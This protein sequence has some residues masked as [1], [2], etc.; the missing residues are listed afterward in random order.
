ME[1]YNFDQDLSQ[2]AQSWYERNA[3]G[4]TPEQMEGLLDDV[5]S[6]WL[7]SVIPALGVTPRAYFEVLS[8]QRLADL[9]IAYEEIHAQP[10]VMME[11]I[12]ERKSMIPLL[13]D[14]LRNAV[15]GER[16]EMLIALLEEMGDTSVY[17]LYLDWICDE[18][19]DDEIALHAIEVMQ[20]NANMVAREL[21][22]RLKDASDKVK[23]RIAD[24]IVYAKPTQDGLQLLIDFFMTGK[25][26]QL[27]AA[28]LG[29]Y[30]DARAI[31]FLKEK[32]KD[33]DYVAFV[34]ITNAV[35][36]LGGDMEDIVRDFSN[37]PAYR[38]IKGA[39]NVE[40]DTAEYSKQ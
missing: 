33:C 16:I 36:R 28:Y 6:A 3:D 1:L 40:S 31:P 5:Y 23:A 39:T 4:M 25:E 38:K 17:E 14:M 11:E 35:E 27:Y 10:A 9:F 32:A 18:D 12:A 22:E 24:V 8:D 15:T 26:L 30:G 21:T 13:I 34:E 29:M 37:D 7:E 20:Q 2:F 19:F